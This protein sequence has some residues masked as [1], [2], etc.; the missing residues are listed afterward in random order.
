M[1]QPLVL[2]RSIFATCLLTAFATQAEQFNF[3]FPAQNLAAT[4]DDLS[5]KSHVRLMYSPEAVKGAIY[6]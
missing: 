6:A 4:P 5:G 2:R 3:N 1:L